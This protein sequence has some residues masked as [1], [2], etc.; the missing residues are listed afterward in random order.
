[1]HSPTTLLPTATTDMLALLNCSVVCEG[2]DGFIDV[3]YKRAAGARR[4][5]N[6]SCGTYEQAHLLHT[7]L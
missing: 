2:P 1:M 6:A 3:A 4:T 7:L 5:T